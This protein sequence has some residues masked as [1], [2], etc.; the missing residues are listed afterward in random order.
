[1]S[2]VLTDF[3]LISASVF[4]FCSD[5]SALCYHAQNKIKIERAD[6]ENSYANRLTS[7]TSENFKLFPFTLAYPP[8][9]RGRSSLVHPPDAARCVLCQYDSDRDTLV[10]ASSYSF[11]FSAFF[12]VFYLLFCFSSCFQ[13]F[14]FVTFVEFV[15]L[16]Y[17]IYLIY[18]VCWYVFSWFVLQF[19]VTDYDTVEYFIFGASVFS[20]FPVCKYT[21][22]FALVTLS[23]LKELVKTTDKELCAAFFLSTGEHYDERT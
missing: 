3:A 20:C 11:L 17:V 1:M 9:S 23:S 14:F 10:V 5:F 13:F 4:L 12:S 8:T 15:R 19:S 2:P 16:I 22:V 6:W 21:C 7:A 18:T